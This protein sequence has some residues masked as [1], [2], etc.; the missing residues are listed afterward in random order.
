MRLFSYK[1]RLLANLGLV[2]ATILICAVCAEWGL[3]LGSNLYPSFYPTRMGWVGQFQNR[4]STTFV[5]D[6]ETGWRMRANNSFDWVIGREEQTYRSNSQGFR[7][8]TDFDKGDQRA[9][10]AFV[11]DSFTFGTGVADDETFP[12]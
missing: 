6:A 3:Q 9:K 11:G 7:S 1:W 12:A 4:P 8:P 10:F 5:M 2:C